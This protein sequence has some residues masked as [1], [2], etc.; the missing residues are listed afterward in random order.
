MGKAA[1]QTKATADATNNIPG[2]AAGGGN[3]PNP[4]DDDEY[5]RYLALLK[6]VGER[7]SLLK[8]FSLENTARFM[9]NRELSS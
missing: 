7:E 9:G 4:P 3:P 2:A 8:A 1:E 5:K 6:E